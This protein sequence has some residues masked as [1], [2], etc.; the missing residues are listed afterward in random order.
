M[1]HYKLSKYIHKLKEN[2][3]E[4]NTIV[5]SNKKTDVIPF[6]AL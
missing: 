6:T 5:F 3:Y 4:Q 1:S 2:E